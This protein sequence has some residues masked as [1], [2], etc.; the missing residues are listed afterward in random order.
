[1]A[2]V[3]AR[4]PRGGR[5]KARV[6]QSPSSCTGGVTRFAKVLTLVTLVA[7][8][9]SLVVWNEDSGQEKDVKAVQLSGR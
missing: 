8:L 2:T 5:G 4:D 1:M 3:A 6:R 9:L 7:I